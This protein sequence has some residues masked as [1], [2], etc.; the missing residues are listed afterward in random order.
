MSEDNYAEIRR[1]F[2]ATGHAHV[3]VFRWYKTVGY[4]RYGRT[5]HSLS[6]PPIIEGSD[7]E[8]LGGHEGKIDGR[9]MTPEEVTSIRELLVKMDQGAAD[10]WH[11][12]NTIVVIL[13]KRT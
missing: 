9:E 13:D 8:Y 2:N 1:W 5:S 3:S 11:G 6:S 12:D 7:I 10:T 4:A